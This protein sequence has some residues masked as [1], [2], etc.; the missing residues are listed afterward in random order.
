MKHCSETAIGHISRSL[1]CM[2]RVIFSF[3][4]VG[5][6][7]GVCFTMD[8]QYSFGV[9]LWKQSARLLQ[10]HGG[11]RPA[12][13]PASHLRS[14]LPGLSSLPLFMSLFC[15]KCPQQRTGTPGDVTCS[16]LPSAM[17]STENTDSIYTV[18]K[19]HFLNQFICC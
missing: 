16:N 12:A 19:L 1:S 8:F 2:V 14:P 11:A 3:N 6:C 9:T 17:V 10:R 18:F 4:T 7:G 5:S 13:E 15:L